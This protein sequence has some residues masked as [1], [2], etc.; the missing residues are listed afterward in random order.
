MHLKGKVLMA[1]LGN[2][3]I[4][5]AA[6]FEFVKPRNTRRISSRLAELGGVDL[7]GS[8]TG[9]RLK[10]FSKAE[11]ERDRAAHR[12]V[13]HVVDGLED[14]EGGPSRVLEE[15]EEEEEEEEDLYGDPGMRL[16]AEGELIL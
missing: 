10:K 3:T 2:L 1:V 16:E 4:S 9:D 15:V 8:F 12:A 13:I 14:E 11:L 5:C 7:A 6:H